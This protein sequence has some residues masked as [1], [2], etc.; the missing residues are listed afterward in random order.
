MVRMDTDTREDGFKYPSTF[1]PQYGG[2]KH[3]AL[4]TDTPNSLCGLARKIGRRIVGKVL[5]PALV[6]TGSRGGQVVL[7][8]LLRCFWRGPFININAGL[9]MSDEPVPAEAMAYY[10]TLG[11]EGWD[12]S[13]PSY[14]HDVHRRLTPHPNRGYNVHLFEHGHIPMLKGRNRRLLLR[15]CNAAIV[16]ERPSSAPPMTQD[17][18]AVY[19]LSSEAVPSRTSSANVVTVQSGRHANVKLRRR[20]T[21]DHD[22]YADQRSA[23]NGEIV[24]VLDY[25]A[26]EQGFAMLQIGAGDRHGWIYTMN[27]REFQS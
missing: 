9:L 18:H 27:I 25:G 3:V 10:L 24:H 15:L 11:G 22:W 2:M 26:D 8:L 17:H 4:S 23:S 13:D 21:G 20:A 12:T 6:I 1:Y 19:D 14:V 5:A 16:G 7:P